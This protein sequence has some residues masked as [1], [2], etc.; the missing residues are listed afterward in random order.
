MEMVNC[1][2]GVPSVSVFQRGPSEILASVVFRTPLA[3][4]FVD[5]QVGAGLPGG[6][7]HSVYVPAGSPKPRQRD[8]SRRRELCRRVRSRTPHIPRTG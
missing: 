3:C 1:S 2:T 4:L 6:M 5:D 8:G 7:V